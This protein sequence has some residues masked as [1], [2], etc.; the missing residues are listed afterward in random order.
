[1]AMIIVMGPPGSG[2]G[3]RIREASYGSLISISMGEILRERGI[4][5]SS[6]NLVSDKV[7][8]SI[9]RDAVNSVNAETIIFDGI[10]RT[11]TQ[12][13]M[14]EQI[15]IK[16]DKLIVLQL[17]EEE[18]VKRALSRYHCPNCGTEYNTEFRPPKVANK[19]D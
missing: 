11:I 14:L 15:G 5:T 2:K 10:P 9:L 6:G 13:E 19:C 8:M 17:S 1:M 18:A 4:D 7:V 3:T 16:V 12:A